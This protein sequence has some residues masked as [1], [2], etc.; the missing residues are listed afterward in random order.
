MNKRSDTQLTVRLTADLKAAL[1]EQAD[2]EGK[3]VTDLAVSAIHAYLGL[4]EPD[5]GALA[6]R[7]ADAARVEE[8]AEALTALQA[9]IEAQGKQLSALATGKGELQPGK[10]SEAQPGGAKAKPRAV[11]TSRGAK[12]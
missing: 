10:K 9:T 3:T 12:D 5:S 2:R 1:R 11:G 4:T 7:F 6:A 8:L